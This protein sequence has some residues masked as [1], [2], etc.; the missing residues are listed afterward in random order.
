MEL[1][2]IIIIAMIVLSAELPE[3]DCLNVAQTGV[4]N[5]LVWNVSQTVIQ[6]TF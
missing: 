1:Q 3:I 5:R 4:V 6:S 2:K